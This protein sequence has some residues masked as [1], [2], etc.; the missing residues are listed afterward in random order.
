MTLVSYENYGGK[1]GAKILKTIAL[2][3]GAYISS[4]ILLKTTSDS[5]SNYMKNMTKRLNQYLVDIEKKKVYITQ[6]VKH[7]LVFHLGIVPF[8]RR[9]KKQYQGVIKIWKEKGMNVDI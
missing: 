9:N 6:K 8:V 7:D 2:Y 5:Y 1:Q 4:S 3:S